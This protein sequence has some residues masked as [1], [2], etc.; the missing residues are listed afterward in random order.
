[1]ISYVNAYDELVRRIGDME[2]EA[3]AEVLRG[4]YHGAVFTYLNHFLNV[5][6]AKHPSEWVGPVPGSAREMLD[7]LLWC[8]E[9]QQVDEAGAVTWAYLQAGHRVEDLYAALA[10]IV[11]REDAA[12]RTDQMLEA[13]SSGTRSWRAIR[14][15]TSRWPP[16]PG[17]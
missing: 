13:A 8:G 10:Q 16:R 1:M 5:P 17:T 2:P 14:T 6:R 12:F 3:T 4:L 15:R 11:L 7:R 9:F